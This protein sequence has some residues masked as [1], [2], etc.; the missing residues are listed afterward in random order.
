MRARVVIFAKA[1]VPGL[2]KTRLIPALGADGAAQLAARMLERTVADAGAAGLGVPELCATPEPN[3]PEWRGRAP[4]GVRSTTQGEG[5]LG[6]RLARAA[7]R[8]IEEGEGVLLIGTDCPELDAERLRAAARKLE[9]HDAV[10]YPASDGGYVLLGLR[11][12]DPSLFSGIAWSTSTVAADTAARVAA[13][14]WTLFTGDTLSDIDEPA[15]LAACD[16]AI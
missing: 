15:D 12:F 13:L 10:I 5:N 9:T 16:L 3:A 11:R 7:G 2:A 8:V 1:P 4:A 6:E 14:G